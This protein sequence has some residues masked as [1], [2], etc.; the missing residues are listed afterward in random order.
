MKRH[1]KHLLFLALLCLFLLPVTA[2]A[3]TQTVKVVVDG[4]AV[5][6]DVF[7]VIENN[8]TLI[9]LRGV[10]ENMGAKVEWDQQNFLVT[11]TKDDTVI[12]LHP[13]S[14]TVYVNNQ[15]ILLDVPSKI[16]NGRTMVPLRFVSEAVGAKVDW[17]P[18]TYTV[19]IST[20][21]YLAL[22]DLKSKYPELYNALLNSQKIDRGELGVNVDFLLVAGQ[23]GSYRTAVSAV[24]K[25]NKN[26]CEVN[27]KINV[28]GLE[29]SPAET[30]FQM[31]IKDG[32]EYV[33]IGEENWQV[34]P[35]EEPVQKDELSNF[36]GD[37]AELIAGKK[38]VTEE[39]YF[40]GEKA[41]V[42]KIAFPEISLDNMELDKGLPALFELK[43]GSGELQI[44]VKDG[45][46]AKIAANIVGT[47]G[48]PGDNSEINAKIN[49]E[50]SVKEIPQDFEIKAPVA[51]S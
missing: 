43:K 49:I 32:F 20:P 42:Y 15:P 28:S 14:K 45:Y 18:K 11:I 22:N 46:V 33:K 30:D 6:F 25:F 26:D 31:V 9:P 16:V 12:K 1:F 21:S 40:D 3:E 19:F 10:F 17:D 50:I 41:T 34:Q 44:V 5:K 4:S 48:V 29:N 24:G 35:L 8:R 23:Q 37:F 51:V 7:P 2:L 13:N 38:I 39:T 47:V 27:G 36:A